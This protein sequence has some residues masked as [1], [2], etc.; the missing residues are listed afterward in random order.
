MKSLKSK[1]Q[2]GTCMGVAALSLS[3]VSGLNAMWAAG[4]ATTNQVGTALIAAVVACVPGGK[5]SSKAAVAIQALLGKGANALSKNWYD[6]LWSVTDI[7]LA[8]VPGAVAGKIMY[9]LVKLIPLL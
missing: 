2:T 5:I 3:Q 4:K 8:F 6:L 9:Q 7:A 1:I